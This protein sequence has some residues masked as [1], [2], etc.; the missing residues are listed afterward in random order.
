M[1]LSLCPYYLTKSICHILITK[2]FYGS[3]IKHIKII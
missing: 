1:K 2:R 3:Q